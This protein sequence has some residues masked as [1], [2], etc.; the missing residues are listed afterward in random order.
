MTTAQ[1][2]YVAI[3]QVARSSIV[4]RSRLFLLKEI[5]RETATTYPN[6]GFTLDVVCCPFAALV[7]ITKSRLPAV[8]EPAAS[9]ICSC[10]KPPGDEPAFSRIA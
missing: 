7:S 6:L 1:H 2:L 4:E 3:S 9:N 8:G 5:F 10:F